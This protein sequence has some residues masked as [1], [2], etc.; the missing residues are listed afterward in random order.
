[1]NSLYRCAERIIESFTALA[2]KLDGGRDTSLSRCS[3][4]GT[5]G[6]TRIRFPRRPASRSKM[7][8]L[9]AV[10]TAIS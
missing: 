5:Y 7:A 2:M 6:A 1:M 3:W 9:E 8:K 4:R 10:S